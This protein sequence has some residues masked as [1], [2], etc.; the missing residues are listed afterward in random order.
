MAKLKQDNKLSVNPDIFTSW[1]AAREVEF[2][3]KL[4]K[5]RESNPVYRQ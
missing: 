3:Q 1:S 2:E 5:L 4:I